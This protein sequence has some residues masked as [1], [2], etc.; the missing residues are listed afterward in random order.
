MLS[1]TAAHVSVHPSM[2]QPKYGNTGD[3]S[4]DSRSRR[5][6]MPRF[7]AL[8]A[9]MAKAIVIDTDG[10]VVLGWSG[11]HCKI[12]SASPAMMKPLINQRTTWGV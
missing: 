11:P 9:T 4:G 6:T 7:T 12:A 2:I 1:S 10:S 8:K 5:I 3:D